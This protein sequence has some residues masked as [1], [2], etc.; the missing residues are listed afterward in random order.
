MNIK[1]NFTTLEA[2]KRGAAIKRNCF[3]KCG[4]CLI[5]WS[6]TNTINIHYAI[7]LKEKK[8]KE[9]FFCD[10]CLKNQT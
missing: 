2:F 5:K 10:N 4:L 6:Q 7:I 1:E 9:I 8:Q 3:N